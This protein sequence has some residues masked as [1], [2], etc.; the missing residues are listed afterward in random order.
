MHEEVGRDVDRLGVAIASRHHSTSAVDVNKLRRHVADKTDDSVGE[1]DRALKEEDCEQSP[2]ERLGD[3]DAGLA[4]GRLWVTL[5]RSSW[6]GGTLGVEDGREARWRLALVLHRHLL[7]ELAVV[8]LAGIARRSRNRT[9]HVFADR[10]S[11]WVHVAVNL[12][13]E[14]LVERHGVGR[15]VALMALYAGGISRGTAS[16]EAGHGFA[17]RGLLYAEVKKC[18]WLCCLACDIAVKADVCMRKRAIVCQREGADAAVLSRWIKNTLGGQRALARKAL[19]SKPLVDKENSEEQWKAKA[20][21]YV[22]LA[23]AAGEGEGG[24]SRERKQ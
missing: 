14:V 11:A 16:F 22:E 24:E 17:G 23:T 18:C 7:A 13:L 6:R 21:V 20:I 19:S 1:Q 12:R 5:E 9:L 4:N 15:C 3:V 10:L 2:E 8:S